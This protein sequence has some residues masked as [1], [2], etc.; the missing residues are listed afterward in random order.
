[1]KTRKFTLATLFLTSTIFLTAC[2]GGSGSG[3]VSDAA[4][5]QMVAT[6]TT[7]AT[8]T[9]SN[10]S[11]AVGGVS[12]PF[13]SHLTA[14]VAGIKPT[15]SSQAAQDGLIRTQYNAWKSR[16]VQSTC[17]GNAVTFTSSY[18]TVSEGA[19]YGMLLSVLMAGHDAQARALFDGLL[20]VVRSH[21]AY[22]TGYPA[23]MEWRVNNDCSS[24]GD[25]WNA[26][27]GD[28]D[29]AMALLMADKQWG[30]GGEV[31]YRAEALRTIA[32]LKAFNMTP[33]GFTK[34]LPSASNN[35]TS[36]YMI[37]HFKAFKRATGDTFWDTATDKAFYLLDL[38]QSQFAPTTGLIPDFVI[39][40]ATNPAP[41]TGFIGDGNA[42]EG[43]Y[44]WNACR[45]PWRLASDYVT[46]G[47]T[48]SKV[49]TGKLMDFL[50]T[51]SGG[52]PVGI[53][54][55]YKLDGTAL[56]NNP[57]YASPSFVGPATAGAMVDVRFQPFL[58]ALWSYSSAHLAT[59]Y[60][61][62]ELELLSLI[63]ASGNWWNP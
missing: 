52:R 8:N 38:M 54:M 22:S 42:M 36:D 26:M 16:G 25:G 2:G 41:S 51:S 57:D 3:S 7:P 30:S 43:F 23:L 53:A 5:D 21:P 32:A 34:G 17:G 44:Y 45:L 15:V 31:N 13:A 60:Y 33:D 35:R 14:Y 49:V 29:I 11:A 24:A 6:S 18:L 59:N 39:N 61:D 20:R 4:S 62:T 40:T 12:Y 27:D 56:T 46:S 28:L 58:N 1:M 50:N 63:V 48:R 19:G 55:G 37:T 10:I 9:G 47:D